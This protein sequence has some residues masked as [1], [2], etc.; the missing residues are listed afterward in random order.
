MNWIKRFLNVLY[1]LTGVTGRRKRALRYANDWVEEIS[2]FLKAHDQYENV[3][4]DKFLEKIGDIKFEIVV[5]AH[6]GRNLMGKAGHLRDKPTS[7]LI[8]EMA[9]NVNSIRRFLFSPTVQ[10][11]RIRQA[12]VNLKTSSEKLQKSLAEIKSR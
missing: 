12:L 3:D 1:H 4:I 8:T 6:N 5:L 11:E 9:D 7:E 10:K 2:N